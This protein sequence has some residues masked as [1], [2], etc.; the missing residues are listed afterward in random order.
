MTE[1]EKKAAV[2]AAR[3]KWT[4]TDVDGLDVGANFFIVR[5]P[6]REELKRWRANILSQQLRAGATDELVTMCVLSPDATA[7]GKI[8]DRKPFV[9]EAIQSLVFELGGMNED[10]K[11]KGF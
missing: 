2:A 1:D 9:T 8:L 6:T 7:L 11:K 5:G 10:A 4:T 3:T